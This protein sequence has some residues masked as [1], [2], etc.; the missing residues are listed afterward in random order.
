[1]EIEFYNNEI[2]KK[3]SDMEELKKIIGIE[4]AKMVKLRFN[5]I[6]ASEDFQ[7]FMQNGFGKPHPL[8]GNLKKYFGVG[9]TG[10]YRLVI[11]PKGNKKVIVRGVIDY[12]GDK[13]NWLIP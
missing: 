6:R 2:Q 8:K 5:Q 9:L 3:M 7:E 13:Y 11:L 10:N 1:M 4:L 12:H